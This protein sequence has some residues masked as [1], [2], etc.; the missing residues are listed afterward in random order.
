MFAS[1]G[2]ASRDMEGKLT[3]SVDIY[4]VEQRVRAPSINQPE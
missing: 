2:G 4:G 1:L 3:C